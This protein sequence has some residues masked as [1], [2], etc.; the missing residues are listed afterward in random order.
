MG[1]SSYDLILIT[2]PQMPHLQVLLTYE[3]GYCIWH[4][5]FGEN[6][7]IIA[8]TDSLIIDLRGRIMDPEQIFSLFAHTHKIKPVSIYKAM[9]EDRKSSL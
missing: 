9:R 6:F 1:C 5:D 4:M 3:F 7:Q 2:Y 8:D